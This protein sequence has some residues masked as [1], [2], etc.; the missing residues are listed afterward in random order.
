M[1]KTIFL[2]GYKGF[3]GMFI[4]YGVGWKAWGAE[5]HA[6]LE[7][8]RRTDRDDRQS[9]TVCRTSWLADTLAPSTVRSK[10]Y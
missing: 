3:M 5:V 9:A 10:S 1:Q 7:E 6:V 4:A 8:L 2:L